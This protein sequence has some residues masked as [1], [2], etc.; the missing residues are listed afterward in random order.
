MPLVTEQRLKLKKHKK[1]SRE[2]SFLNSY[3]FQY[4]TRFDLI[5]CE[6]EGYL[7]LGRT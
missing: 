7:S 6:K 1:G 2:A 3:Y 5:G 4:L